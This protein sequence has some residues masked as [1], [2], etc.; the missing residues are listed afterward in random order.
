MIFFEVH[1][2]IFEDCFSGV[3]YCISFSIVLIPA[4]DFDLVGLFVE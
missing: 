1:V 2:F 3:L 4:F